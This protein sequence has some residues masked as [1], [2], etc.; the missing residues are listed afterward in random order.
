MPP[1]AEGRFWL[2]G[3]GI[4]AIVA[5]EATPPGFK[6]TPVKYQPANQEYAD[7]VRGNT[8]MEELTFKHARA[9]GPAGRELVRWLVDY[10]AGIRVEKK[11]F[12]F[13]T[14]DESGIRPVEIWELQDCVPTMYK[15]ESG[16]GAGTNVATFSFNLQPTYAR[17][18]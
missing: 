1:S 4:T 6:H 2:E 5:T 18:V 13:I 9:V 11:N 10:A 16:S 12:R 8:E 3:D 17:L 14:L 7:H 15:P